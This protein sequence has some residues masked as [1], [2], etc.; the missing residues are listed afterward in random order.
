MQISDPRGRPIEEVTLRLESEE[1]TQ[2]LVAASQ[3]ED[4][5]QD[6]ALLRDDA[7]NTVAVY[8]DRGEPPPL[9]RH[10]DWWLG[11][12][13]LAAVVLMAIGAFTIAKGIVSLLF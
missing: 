4:G 9:E 1:L 6:H 5:T 10:F 7:G 2:L 8:R 12:L 13:V 11:P 3:L